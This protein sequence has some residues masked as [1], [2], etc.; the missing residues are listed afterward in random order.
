MF[1]NG[2]DYSG[3]CRRIFGESITTRQ[4]MCVALWRTVLLFT[5]RLFINCHCQK[6]WHCRRTV[7]DTPGIYEDN[8]EPYRDKKN[9]KI[10]HFKLA[11]LISNS[12]RYVFDISPN[13]PPHSPTYRLLV[14]NC[15]NLGHGGEPVPKLFHDLILRQIRGQYSAVYFQH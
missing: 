5:C 15:K 3:T 9:I 12:R 13:C 2:Q 6:Y 1:P 14:T 7:P 8:L 11:T 4:A 10:S